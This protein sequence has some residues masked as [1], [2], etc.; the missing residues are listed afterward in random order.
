MKPIELTSENFN[1]EVSESE[2]P[3][4]ADFWAPWCGPCRRIGPALERLAEQYSGQVK[5]G[6]INV[7]QQRKLASF[8]QIR[9]IPT[10]IVFSNGTAGE[11]VVGFRGERELEAL[12]AKLAGSSTQVAASLN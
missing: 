4:V 7:D 10:L 6:K 12:F 1:R 8:Y 9:G 3:V 5:V 11:Q 2:I